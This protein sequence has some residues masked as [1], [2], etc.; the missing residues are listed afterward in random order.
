LADRQLGEG[1]K[2][3][4]ASGDAPV[5][6]GMNQPTPVVFRASSRRLPGDFTPTFARALNFVCDWADRERLSDVPFA[7]DW[8][9]Y[10]R[11]LAAHLDSAGV[12]YEIHCHSGD[13]I[14]GWR[15]AESA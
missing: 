6:E 11:E 3:T 8:I 5:H 15:M 14:C 12:P 7:N 2:N 4:Q 9:Y 1:V 10:P 13:V